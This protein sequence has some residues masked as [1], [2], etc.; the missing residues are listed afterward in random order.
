MSVTHWVPFSEAAANSALSLCAQL[1]HVVH[2][3][4]GTERCRKISPAHNVQYT[5]RLTTCTGWGQH[6]G[7]GARTTCLPCPNRKLPQLSPHNN[8]SPWPTSWVFI[9]RPLHKKNFCHRGVP[10]HPPV[11]FHSCRLPSFTC[12][13]LQ[14]SG[15]HEPT[16]TQQ[17]RSK[18]S[19]AL[20]DMYNALQ[21]TYKFIGEQRCN[22][23][24]S[25][26][27]HGKQTKL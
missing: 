13:S 21:H 9:A 5:K 2:L 22:S 17:L 19:N 14:Y 27:V 8:N 23:Y 4:R 26:L 16:A 24:Y 10:Q 12:K 25:C 3:F 20:P 1:E 6:F 7:G 15:F 11:P 18:K